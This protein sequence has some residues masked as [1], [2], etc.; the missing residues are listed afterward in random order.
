MTDVRST[1]SCSDRFWRLKATQNRP[2]GKATQNNARRNASGSPQQGAVQVH[3][4]QPHQV[5]AV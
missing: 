2:T 1:T 3:D 4:S 5:L